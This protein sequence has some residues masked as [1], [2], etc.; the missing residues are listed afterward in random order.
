MSLHAYQ[1]QVVLTLTQSV[2]LPS[3]LDIS[4]PNVSFERKPSFGHLEL[5]SQNITA[6]FK[7]IRSYEQFFASNGTISFHHDVEDNVADDQ[8]KRK[9]CALDVFLP[10]GKVA[11]LQ[12]G[13]VDVPCDSADLV[14][15]SMFNSVLSMCTNAWK[16]PGTYWMKSMPAFYTPLNEIT[17]LIIQKQ[18]DEPF[19]FTLNFTAVSES[20]RPQLELISV[21]E[22]SGMQSTQC[23]ATHTHTHTHTQ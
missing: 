23:I 10:A 9:E 18:G 2:V 4:F 3:V 19:S 1:L 5:T 14:I 17:I 22:T 13:D 20:E 6:C 12:F 15:K 7:G 8:L 21:T 11:R 16:T